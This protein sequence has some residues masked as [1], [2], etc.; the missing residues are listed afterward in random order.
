M[1]EPCPSSLVTILRVL[2]RYMLPACLC[3]CGGLAESAAAEPVSVAPP[4]SAYRLAVRDQIEVSVFEEPDLAST[5]RIDAEGQI[6]LGLIGTVLIAGSTVRE[7][8]EQIQTQYIGQKFL[9]Q[10]MVTIRILDYAPREAMVNGAVLSPGPFTFP[11]E[12][13]I[14]DIVEVITKRGGF[15]TIARDNAV[16]VTRFSEKGRET[17]TV[18]VR[19]M[20]LGRNRNHFYILPG[21]VIYVDD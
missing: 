5:Q 20:L 12:A 7:A 19:D 2:A 17:F 9:R 4:A 10:P 6:R 18:Q 1:L 3:L 16:R 15:K 13:A 21:D 8:E 11:P 14:V